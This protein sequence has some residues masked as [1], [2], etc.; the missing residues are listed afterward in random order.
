MLYWLASSAGVPRYRGKPLP[1]FDG[2]RFHNLAPFPLPG[3]G[4][5]LRWKLTTPH[6]EWPSWV[7]F[8][9]APAPPTRVAEGARITFIN[10]A[11]VLIQLAGLNILTDPVYSDTIGPISWFGMKRHKAPGIPFE[12]LPKIDVVL[13]SHNHYDHL[14]VPTLRRLAARDAPK[15]LAGLGNAAFLEKVGLRDNVDLELWQDFR[16]G[17]VTFTL[18][19]TQHWSSRSINDRCRALWGGFYVQS[20]QARIYFAGDTGFGSH[21]ADTTARLGAPDV[22]LLPIGSFE[23]RWFMGA[24][25][26]SPEEAVAAHRALAAKTSIAIHFGCFDLASDGMTA[27]LEALRSALS[28]RRMPAGCFRWLEHGESYAMG[29]HARP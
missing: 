27:P 29:T 1:Y 21:F 25:H 24:Q 11:T 23:P 18:T 17:S 16:L 6:G 7:E 20:S 14:D 19:P 28:S 8:P 9:E 15:I 4:A 3:L 10:H 13:L 12:L 22:A 2:E 26:M 5:V